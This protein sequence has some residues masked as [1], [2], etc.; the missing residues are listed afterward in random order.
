MNG[1][2][3]LFALLGL[4]VLEFSGHVFERAIGYY[5]KW[6]N[7]NRPQLGRIWE[8]DRKKIVAQKKIESILS[9]VSSQEQDSESIQSFKELFEKLNPANPQMVSR[10]K[11]LKLYYDF[12]EKLAK[13]I[14]SPYE[15]LEIDSNKGWQRVLLTQLGEWI[16]LSFINNQNYPIRE[17]FLS[18]EGMEGNS[19][20]RDI[21]K[22]TLE[23]AGFGEGSI[24]SVDD[25]MR[26]L[27]TLDA[28]AQQEIFPDPYWFFSKNYHVTRVGVL[29]DSASDLYP[30]PVRIGVEYQSDFY[31][32]VLTLPVP[33]DI[34]ENLLSLIEVPMYGVPPV[35]ITPSEGAEGELH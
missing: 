1:Y 4:G 27:R 11:F 26:V 8:R 9:S 21:F 22:G 24:V 18:W 35:P 29:E 14:I 32:E 7:L 12:P 17:V 5:L 6:E 19:L 13:K 16:T 15:L 3:F 33:G 31:T 25:F 2:L 30:K 34:S 20:N 28:T 23:E 10:K